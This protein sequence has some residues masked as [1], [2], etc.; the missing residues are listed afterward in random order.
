MGGGE[1]KQKCKQSPSREQRPDTCTATEAWP[2]PPIPPRLS[3]FFNPGACVPASTAQCT[4]PHLCQ[5]SDHFGSRRRARAGSLPVPG[6][7]QS[8]HG[9]WDS[10]SRSNTAA[11]S[12]GGCWESRRPQFPPCR[13]YRRCHPVLWA[14]SEGT[15]FQGGLHEAAGLWTQGPHSTESSTTAQSRNTEPWAGVP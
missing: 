4:T 3:R 1:Q 15:A 2:S 14:W 8:P 12:R 7:P 6:K 9:S 13:H 10:G 11:Q 5:G